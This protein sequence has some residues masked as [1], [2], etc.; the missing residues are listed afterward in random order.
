MRPSV[1]CTINKEYSVIDP[2]SRAVILR[3]GDTFRLFQDKQLSSCGPTWDSLSISRRAHRVYIAVQ[4]HQQYKFM[5]YPQRSYV[6]VVSFRTFWKVREEEKRASSDRDSQVNC[7]A[8]IKCSSGLFVT[9]LGHRGWETGRGSGI[10]TIT[11]M[12][13]GDLQSHMMTAQM[14]YQSSL[15]CIIM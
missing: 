6:K 15:C 3:Y 5:M 8:E 9:A 14:H 2:S 7:S 10:S 13:A 1:L 4:E 11:F 12:R